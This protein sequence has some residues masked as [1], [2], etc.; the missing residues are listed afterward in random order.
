MT[1][2]WCAGTPTP[3]VAARLADLLA[4]ASSA[5]SHAIGRP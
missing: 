1:A 3:M 4:V 2:A 5:A